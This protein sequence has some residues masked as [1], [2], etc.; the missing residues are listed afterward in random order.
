M[1]Y[2]QI[3]SHCGER[4]CSSIKC[5][6]GHHRPRF[7]LYVL[8][9]SFM[10]PKHQQKFE[11]KPYMR[12]CLVYRQSF[13]GRLQ[14]CFSVQWAHTCLAFLSLSHSGPS[15]SLTIASPPCIC[16]PQP[17]SFVIFWAIK[18]QSTVSLRV[19]HS[20]EVTEAPEGKGT[21][22]FLSLFTFCPGRF[23]C[24]FGV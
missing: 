8:T 10:N 23:S 2:N 4:V 5:S 6:Q 3:S 13:T 1:A 22:Y 15:H 18:R 9:W 16:P 14:S 17:R 12:Q 24:L 21:L 20:H 7:N 19:A 11:S